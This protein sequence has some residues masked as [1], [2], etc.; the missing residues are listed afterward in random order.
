M[1][2]KLAGKRLCGCVAGGLSECGHETATTAGTVR[3]E[4][5]SNF[6]S[7]SDVETPGIEVQNRLYPRKRTTHPLWTDER[8]RGR[9]GGLPFAS[10]GRTA[11]KWKRL[12]HVLKRTENG[13]QDAKGWLAQR[14]A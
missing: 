1:Y 2:E 6:H 14:Q 8:F 11:V 4:Q 13:R 10:N 3:A 12:D 7:N 9:D 5:E